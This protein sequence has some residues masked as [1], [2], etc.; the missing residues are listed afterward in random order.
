M[1]E[2]YSGTPLAKKLGIKAGYKVAF[3][4]IPNHYFNLFDTIPE[5]EE[6]DLDSLEIDFVHV[7]VTTMDQLELTSAKVMKS[8][9]KTGMVW[10]S[11]PKKTSLI[12]TEL[13]RDII[14]SYVLKAGLVDTKVCAVDKDWSGL[15]FMFRTKDR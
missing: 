5:V 13:D 6:V 14:R 2:G 8:L 7:F 12:P 11:W 10:Y 3:L 4:N 15:K 9:K 1:T